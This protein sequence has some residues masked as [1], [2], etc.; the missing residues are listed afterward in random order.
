MKRQH[1]AL[2]SFC[3]LALFIFAC[4]GGSSGGGGADETALL[5]GNYSLADLEGVWNYVESD[6]VEPTIITFNALGVIVSKLEHGVEIT[7]MP[8]IQPYKCYPFVVQP[9]GSATGRETFHF[10]GNFTMYWT[11]SFTSKTV[12][13]GKV[14]GVCPEGHL[15][16]THSFTMNRIH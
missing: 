3:A 13:T 16:E 14:R 12:I 10:G 4:D 8:A 1:I 6:D 9:D 15:D 5:E 7:T 11:F 2:W